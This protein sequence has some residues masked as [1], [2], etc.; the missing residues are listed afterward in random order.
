MGKT[1]LDYHNENTDPHAIIPQSFGKPK[2]RVRMP[3]G[4]WIGSTE[5]TRAQ[6]IAIMGADPRPWGD[7]LKSSRIL[8]ATHISWSSATRFCERLTNICRERNELGPLERCALPTEAQWEYACRAGA[9]S[10]FSFGNNPAKGV[11]FAWTSTDDSGTRK[12]PYPVGILKPNAW[13]IYD[14]HGNVIEL[15]RDTSNDEVPDRRVVKGEAWD[16]LI[17]ACG[18]RAFVR[19]DSGARFVGFRIVIESIPG[20]DDTP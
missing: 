17:A 4:Y 18:S 11:D 2:V 13:G 6:W 1:G 20:G 9:D 7:D 5:V 16:W 14:M 8:P 10:T 12:T 3:H 15:C 19:P